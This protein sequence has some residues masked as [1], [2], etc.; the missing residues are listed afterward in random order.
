M[1]QASKARARIDKSVTMAIE[2]RSGVRR[3]DLQRKSTRL[4]FMVARH[5]RQLWPI[6]AIRAGHRALLSDCDWKVLRG[7]QRCRATWSAS[8]SV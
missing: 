4:T 3:G 2:G 1:G 5:I 8:N 7:G 6:L